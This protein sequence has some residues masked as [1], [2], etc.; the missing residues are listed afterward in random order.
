M[1]LS[2]YLVELP[3]TT[4]GRPPQVSNSEVT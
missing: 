4:R 1:N 3:G 2:T